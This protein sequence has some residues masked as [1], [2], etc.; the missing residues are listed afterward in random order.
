MF[1]GE[2]D[3][4]LDGHFGILHMIE[5]INKNNNNCSLKNLHQVT[6]RLASLSNECSH[7]K[8]RILILLNYG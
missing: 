8:V 2:L 5:K 4:L 1:W 6:G 7:Q 3:D